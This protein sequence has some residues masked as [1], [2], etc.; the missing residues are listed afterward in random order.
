MI[1]IEQNWKKEQCYNCKH[2]KNKKNY[3]VDHGLCVLLNRITFRTYS[4]N[5]FHIKNNQTKED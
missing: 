5:Q 3:L 1:M 4:C 2:W